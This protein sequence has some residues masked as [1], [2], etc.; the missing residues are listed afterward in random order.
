MQTYLRFWPIIGTSWFSLIGQ[1]VKSWSCCL[2]AKSEDQPQVKQLAVT[3]S[4]SILFT[5]VAGFSVQMTVHP[6]L[7]VVAQLDD[8]FQILTRCVQ[9]YHGRVDKFIGDGM[10]AVFDR[11]DEAVNAAQA[12]QQAVARFNTAQQA[13]QRCAFPTRIAVDT[14]LV[15]VARLSA[16]PHQNETIFGRVVNCAA[17]LL[18]HASPGRVLI[19]QHTWCQLTDRLNVGQERLIVVKEE[20][21]P[22]VVYEW[23]SGGGDARHPV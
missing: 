5:D 6:Q 12:I 18:K 11:P 7:E 23:G 3:R 19:S 1:W 20:L 2:F 21:K 16:C 15:V 14:G 22:V 4:A 17:H 13:R 9:R 10:L 8:Y